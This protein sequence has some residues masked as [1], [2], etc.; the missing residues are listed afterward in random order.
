[1]FGA[2]RVP[3]LSSKILAGLTLWRAVM[4]LRDRASGFSF[5]GYVAFYVVMIIVVIV[6][7]YAG[8]S[9]GIIL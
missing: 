5:I 6:C 7:V 3:T 1:M 8:I 4:W 9:I 2:S